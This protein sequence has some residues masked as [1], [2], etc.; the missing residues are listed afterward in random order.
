MIN[1]TQLCAMR[2]YKMQGVFINVS[3][4][5]KNIFLN[6]KITA[7]HHF[8]QVLTTDRDNLPEKK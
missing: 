4:V 6:I 3:V 1:V 7:Y 8:D 2:T 5:I